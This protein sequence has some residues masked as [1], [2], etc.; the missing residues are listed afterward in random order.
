MIRFLVTCSIVIYLLALRVWGLIKNFYKIRSL[1]NLVKYFLTPMQSSQNKILF[2]PK[3][4]K[5]ASV[6]RRWQYHFTYFGRPYLVLVS[7]LL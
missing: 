4:K 2:A 1:L 6:A 7:I 5:F 3:F